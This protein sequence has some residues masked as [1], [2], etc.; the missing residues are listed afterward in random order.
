MIPLLIF[1]KALLFRLSIASFLGK[2][3][4]PKLLSYMIRT[5]FI[6]VILFHKYGRD[7]GAVL[8]NKVPA[9]KCIGTTSQGR[10]VPGWC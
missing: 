6:M 2:Y 1:A 4:F 5:T 9:N 10:L 8:F 3:R 7:G